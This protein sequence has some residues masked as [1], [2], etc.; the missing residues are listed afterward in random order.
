MNT[1]GWLDNGELLHD[2]NYSSYTAALPDFVKLEAY[3]CVGIRAT[4]PDELDE[5]INQMLNT[6][7]PVIFDCL[8]DKQEIVPMIP[9]ENHIIK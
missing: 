8:V 1:W 2:K 5:K 7:R 9:S 4:T 3:G 6:N